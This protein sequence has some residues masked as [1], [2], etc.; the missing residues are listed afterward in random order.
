MTHLDAVMRRVVPLLTNTRKM[1]MENTENLSCFLANIQDPVSVELDTGT[2]FVGR[3]QL[4]HAD[5]REDQRFHVRID[6]YDR[7]WRIVRSDIVMMIRPSAPHEVAAAREEAMQSPDVQAQAEHNRFMQS[8]VDR[9][10]GTGTETLAEVAPQP[11]FG[12]LQPIYDDA[13]WAQS[14]L[15]HVFKGPNAERFATLAK[16]VGELRELLMRSGYDL[17]RIDTSAKEGG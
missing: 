8:L 2:L 10:S 13:A 3:V 6:G 17:F 7:S 5:E 11:R 1:M 14:H 12:W 15:E 16:E 4:I 9:S